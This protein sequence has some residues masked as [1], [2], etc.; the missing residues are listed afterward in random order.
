MNNAVVNLHNRIKELEAERDALKAQLEAKSEPV[1]WLYKN[2][3]T[4]TK[5]LAWEQSVGGSEWT[6]LYASPQAIQPLTDEQIR[7]MYIKNNWYEMHD[8]FTWGAASVVARAVEAAIRE[9]K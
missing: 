6:P 4:H 5:Y 9:Q 8:S 7:Q 2:S 1:A 3:N